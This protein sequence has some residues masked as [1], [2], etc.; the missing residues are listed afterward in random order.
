MYVADERGQADLDWATGLSRPVSAFEWLKETDVVTAH[1]SWR[2]QVLLP[3]FSTFKE[4]EDIF[5]ALEEWFSGITTVLRPSQQIDLEKQHKRI[6]IL[7][8]PWYEL[9]RDRPLNS[10]SSGPAGQCFDRLGCFAINDAPEQ[11]DFDGILYG[12]QN[13]L[14]LNLL[15]P[16]SDSHKILALEAYV[17]LS[18]SLSN[19]QHFYSGRVT[20][21]IDGLRENSITVH[22]GLK[23]GFKSAGGVEYNGVYHGSVLFVN[24]DVEYISTILH[25]Y[26]SS[27]GVNRSDC[28]EIEFKLAA[29]LSL[30]YPARISE[31]IRSLSRKEL[32][33]TIQE[34]SISKT[35]PSFAPALVQLCKYHLLDVNDAETMAVTNSM[36][37]LDGK[38][39]LRDLILK[40]LKWYRNQRLTLV[41]NAETVIPFLQGFEKKVAVLLKQGRLDFSKQMIQ[42]AAEIMSNS[43]TKLNP[44]TDLFLLCLFSAFKLEG[45]EEVYLEGTDRC[46]I[47]NQQSDQAAVFAEF[48]ALGS[49]CETYFGCRPMMIGE[50]LA[51]KYRAFYA[52]NQP[53]RSIEAGTL[54]TVYMSSQTDVDQITTHKEQPMTFLEQLNSVQALGIYAVPALIDITLLTTTGRGL[55]LSSFMKPT[56]S[57]M[58]TYAFVASLLFCGGVNA[59]IEVCRSLLL[60][61]YQIY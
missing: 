41:P 11:P 46:P 15:K 55:Y 17:K 40:R 26:L 7:H 8:F 48:W 32:L 56:Q 42:L 22:L 47:Q 19:C 16:L 34:L 29:V 60:P 31:E 50:V 18:E 51:R 21:L 20:D 39:S 54:A 9:V 36:E 61:I 28:L 2:N 37:Y 3:V 57:N 59:S 53:H 58:A 24:Q 6:S 12:Q 49:N 4:S 13:I 45:I 1:E 27:V 14:R 33:L 52:Q 5:K 23:T 38:I 10:L 43:D 44:C 25:T 30:E 35:L